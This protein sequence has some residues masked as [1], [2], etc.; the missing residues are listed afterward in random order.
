MVLGVIIEVLPDET[1]GTVRT[2]GGDQT[3]MFRDP[4]FPNTGLDEGDECMFD[5]TCS[6]NRCIASNLQPVEVRRRVITTPITGD[7]TINQNE[8][9]IVR[10]QGSITGHITVDGGILIVRKGGK[11]TGNITINSGG[12]VK[13]GN[14][15]NAS[16][17]SV[18][19]NNA[20]LIVVE[21]LSGNVAAND[22]SDCVIRPGGKITGNITVRGNTAL[23]VKSEGVVDG[24]VEFG[25]G[26]VLGIKEPIGEITGNI[27]V[28]KDRRLKVS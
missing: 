8:K 10:D 13:I 22:G 25:E 19:I 11:I 4:N 17:E 5:L 23:K 9:W 12:A 2:N 28:R 20:Q 26:E 27:T 15:G 18:E 3:Y 7:Q 14:G 24:S 16:S 1:R 6:G 21:T